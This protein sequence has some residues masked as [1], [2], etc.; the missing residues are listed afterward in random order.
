MLQPVLNEKLEGVKQILKQNRVKKAYAF[1]SVC[2]E[3][4]GENSDIDILIAFEDGL[5]YG[6]YGDSYFNILWAM[7]E[8]LQRPV[9]L[10]TEGSLH[11]PYF[12]K[13]LNQT[14][15]PIYE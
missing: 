5:D 6:T 13:V 12:I 4:F 14:K 7:E 8:L 1:G 2:T 9:D 3:N 15:T 10:V 11:N